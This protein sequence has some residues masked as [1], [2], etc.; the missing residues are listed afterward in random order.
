MVRAFLDRFPTIPQVAVE[1]KKPFSINIDD[2]KAIILSRADNL[3]DLPGLDGDCALMIIP[4]GKHHH[5]EVDAIALWASRLRGYFHK[6][7]STPKLS[8]RILDVVLG[9]H[10]FLSLGVSYDST[11]VVRSPTESSLVR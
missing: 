10:C 6:I 11:P 1:N 3:K 5:G 8:G 4:K 9:I 2:Y 7:K